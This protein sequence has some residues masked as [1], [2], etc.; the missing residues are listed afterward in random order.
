MSRFA[1][2]VLV[3]ATLALG[4]PELRAQDHTLGLNL[5]VFSTPQLGVT[6]LAS[7]SL[8]IRPSVIASWTKST[9]PFGADVET[10]Q[11]GGELDFLFRAGTRDRVTSYYGLGGFITHV[12]SST[13]DGTL[14][15]TQALLG[16]RVR[17]VDRV[18]IFGEVGLGYQEDDRTF[19]H[20]HVGFE[21]MPLGVV[22]FLK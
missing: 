6:W 16:V 8:A 18:A 15:G 3:T 22:V 12:S 20:R 19:N 4:A 17:V 10:T 11:L 14:W 1:L 5:R 7:P 13:G 21:T 9:S 2:S